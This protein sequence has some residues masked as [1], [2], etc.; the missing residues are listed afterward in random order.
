MEAMSTS[1]AEV[2]GTQDLGVIETFAEIEGIEG[3]SEPDRAQALAIAQKRADWEEFQRT[4]RGRASEVPSQSTLDV[5][6]DSI[7]KFKTGTQITNAQAS[8][9]SQSAQNLTEE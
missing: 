4:I 7:K 1:F 6:N 3:L 2:L 8:V 5:I 9:I